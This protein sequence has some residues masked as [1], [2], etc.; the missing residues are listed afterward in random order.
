MDGGW[1][2][3]VTP[4]SGRLV[5]YIRCYA[6]CQAVMAQY[7]QYKQL[8]LYFFG[9]CVSIIIVKTNTTC[10]HIRVSLLAVN[11]T[12]MLFGSISSKT[13]KPSANARQLRHTVSKLLMFYLPDFVWCDCLIIIVQ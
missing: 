6:E 7:Q 5:I 3:A 13:K 4:A 2:A 1:V 8:M 11:C 10:N 9:S 12:S